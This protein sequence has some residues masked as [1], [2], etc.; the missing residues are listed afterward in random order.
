VLGSPHLPLIN[1]A[2]A[3]VAI[4]HIYLNSLMLE[5]NLLSVGSHVEAALGAKKPVVALE[6]TVIAHGLP[7][8]RN[9]ETA[10]RLDPAQRQAH[11]YLARA[12]RQLHDTERAATES[13]L[14]SEQESAAQTADRAA[15]QETV[16]QLAH[17]SF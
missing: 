3:D 4:A 15:L 2:F 9:L 16:R 10:L 12:Y 6:S 17:T 1:A 8:P 5:R 13:R 7:R 14:F 11:F